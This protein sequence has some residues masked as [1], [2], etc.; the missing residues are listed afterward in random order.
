MRNNPCRIH[1]C[2]ALDPFIFP[3]QAQN[4]VIDPSTSS[5]RRRSHERT[6][7]SRCLAV[8]HTAS[9]SSPDVAVAFSHSLATAST[10]FLSAVVKDRG[11]ILARGRVEG[12][13]TKWVVVVAAA[14]AAATAAAAAVAAAAV[15]AAM[16]SVCDGETP[17][18]SFLE[19][20][21][22]CSLPVL[23]PCNEFNVSPGPAVAPAVVGRGRGRRT[24]ARQ[25]IPR[26]R[27]LPPTHLPTPSVAPPPLIS[28]APRAPRCL[29]GVCHRREQSPRSLDSGSASR[30]APWLYIYVL[31]IITARCPI[32]DV[33]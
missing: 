32:L 25:A 4:S 24:N 29:P 3:R 30:C 5:G 1:K 13:R 17:E 8:C 19:Q 11:S 12:E 18:L 20:T 2:I 33:A 23:S 9:V 22:R 21:N 27:S 31:K 16:A 28:S 15:A 26:H 7:V 10:L 14:A 6:H